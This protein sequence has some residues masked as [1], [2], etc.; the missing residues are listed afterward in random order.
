MTTQFWQIVYRKGFFI[1]KVFWTLFGYLKRIINLFQ[2]PFYDI[3]YVF[4]WGTPFRS[5]LYERMVR[6]LSKRL[7]YDIDDM[8]FLGHSSDA[9]KLWKN[10][11]GKNKM[12]YLMKSA[13]HVITC[14]PKLDDF[15]RQFNRNTTDISSTVDT[16]KKY[17]PVNNYKNDHQIVL[18]WSGSHST[19]KYL[20]LLQDVL[21]DLAKQ[22]NYKLLVMG[23]ASF[24]IEGVNVEAFEWNESI[25]INT[26][27]RF[28][29]G[30]Y[31][32]PDEEWVYGKSGLKAIQYMAL[33]IPTIATAIGTNFRI[34]ENGING[35][36]INPN[37]WKSWALKI[38][39]LIL[40]P[41]SRK[42]IG[43]EARKKIVVQYS[44]EANKEKYLQVLQCN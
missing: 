11:K 43:S 4:L 35:F 18:G 38:E 16:E 3:T 33:G 40:N 32:L 34:I 13:N 17:L 25:E 27:Q 23:D 8:V 29:I 1:E 42:E 36:L 22:Y 26:L 21:K 9:N 39:Y 2:I 7:I 31:P 14:T 44:L 24:R 15:V 5:S 28:D 37:D 10:L 19:S 30:L 6:L 41:E 20:Y 12:I